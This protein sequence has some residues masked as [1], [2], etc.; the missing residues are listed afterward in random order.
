MSAAVTAFY[1]VRDVL[2]QN[3]KNRTLDDTTA[4]KLEMMINKLQRQQLQLQLQFRGTPVIG[5]RDIL[6]N[7][8]RLLDRS[9]SEPVGCDPKRLMAQQQAQNQQIQQQQAQNARNVNSSR[10][11]TELCRPYEENGYCKYGDKCQFAHGSNEL[12]SLA[13][14]P[15]YKTELCRTF[16]TI[17]FCPY[18]PRC[19]FI[20]NEDEGRLSQINQLK[21]QGGSGSSSPGSTSPNAVSSP[22]QVQP[23]HH[24]QS[25]QRPRALTFN[26]PL[27]RDSPLG[28]TADSPP[29]SIT[30][31]SPPS[32]S[33]TWLN[34]DFMHGPLR[35]SPPAT[36]PVSTGHFSAF[37]FPADPSLGPLNVDIASLTAGLNSLNLNHCSSSSCA[38]SST[39]SASSTSSEAPAFPSL[40]HDSGLGGDVFCPPSPL[41]SA[42]F[43]ARS[44]SPQDFCRGIRLP[45]FSQ[46]STE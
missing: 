46:L 27:V 15:K 39:S 17:G 9:I 33:P 45:I 6:L 26:L 5:N 40:R 2:L 7:G 23:H 24:H 25:I 34:D 18:G 21:Q 10:Y 8:R 12:R 43:G 3:Q 38:S 31:D 13:R 32:M 11:K 41:D 36:A 42:S 35:Y 37:S 1:D 28:S 20:H 30:S 4:E 14:H 16:H 22:T 44:D 29:S 19:H